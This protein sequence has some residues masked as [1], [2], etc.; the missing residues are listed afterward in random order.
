MIISVDEAKAFDRIKHNFTIKILKPKVEANFL[1]VTNDFCEKF[2]TDT[3][4]NSG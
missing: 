4:V 1:K 3:I 2:K